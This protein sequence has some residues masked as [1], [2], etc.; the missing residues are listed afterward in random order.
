MLLGSSKFGSAWF[1]LSMIKYN[2]FNSHENFVGYS[3]HD[4][5]Q[6]LLYIVCKCRTMA[7]QSKILLRWAHWLIQWSGNQE[8]YLNLSTCSFDATLSKFDSSVKST[9]VTQKNLITIQWNSAMNSTLNI[10][11]FISYL[12]MIHSQD[13]LHFP[14][15]GIHLIVIHGTVFDQITIHRAQKKNRTQRHKNIFAP[16]FESDLLV[17]TIS[18]GKDH[19]G[20]TV[21]R[22]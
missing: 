3:S 2:L 13:L 9:K 8:V 6:S 5:Y 21:W 16:S 10:S 19:Y 17:K 20:S 15:H 1:W 22:P 14:P 11:L 18:Y 4:L 12:F 7:H